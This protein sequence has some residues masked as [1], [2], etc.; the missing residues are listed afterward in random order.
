MVIQ[1]SPDIRLHQEDK[2]SCLLAIGD[3]AKDR[4][5]MKLES[6]ISREL[7]I[8]DLMV[9]AEQIENMSNKWKIRV[10]CE[11]KLF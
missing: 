4:I 6:Y 3:L 7:G 10:G 9:S 11:G 5:E 8:K 1:D 2:P